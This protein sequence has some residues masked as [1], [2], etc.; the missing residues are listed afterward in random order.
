[1]TS[2]TGEVYHFTFNLQA[3]PPVF[4][5]SHFYEYEHNGNLWSC[6]VQRRDWFLEIHLHAT[7]S[8]TVRT[9][10]IINGNVI[11]S[12]QGADGDQQGIYKKFIPW[13][14]LRTKFENNGVFLVVF[15]ILI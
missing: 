13:S 10:S 5:M 9:V 6:C 12:V 14:E 15:I 7:A 4:S 11:R 8:S 1:M 2:T 3:V